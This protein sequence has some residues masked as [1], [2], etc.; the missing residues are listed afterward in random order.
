[1]DSNQI[2]PEKIRAL[3]IGELQ[4]FVAY[5]EKKLLGAQLQEVLTKDHLLALG[6]WS[7][8]RIWLV[9]DLNSQNPLPLLF[10]DELP[11]RAG[12][13]KPIQFFLKSHGVNRRIAKIEAQKDERILH[14]TLGLEPEETKIEVRLFPKGTNLLVFAGDKKI[15]LERVMD[16]T[17]PPQVDGGARDLDWDELRDKWVQARNRSKA[18]PLDPVLEW[19]KNKEK[20]IQKK[21]IALEKM[22]EDL[23]LKKQTP[24]FEIGDWI[25]VNQTARVPSQW[26]EYIDVKLG[27]FE[28]MQRAFEKAKDNKRKI[29]GNL[30]RIEILKK[31][32][33]TLE[34]SEF[35][36]SSKK[37]LSK[38]QVLKADLL[39][40]AGVQGRRFVFSEQFEAVFGKS[41]A[42]NIQL[43]RKAQAW[44]LW[45]HLRDFPGSHAFIRRP[46]N[47]NVS[48]DDLRKVAHWLVK[49]SLGKKASAGE[50]YAIVVTECRHVKPIK[51]DKLGRVT[52][53]HERH[54]V[55]QFK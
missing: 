55:I 7:R 14:M 52:Y 38:N 13:P 32:I 26:K 8:G 16:L 48:D 51:G 37:S 27:V 2:K 11:F 5:A 43:L 39:R 29:E 28:N 6:F 30:A 3:S 19:Q 10:D 31:E 44:D 18:E 12:S 23:L 47:H 15:S 21:K 42:E 35:A 9:F 50:K 34:R 17:A 46:R 1:M 22:E 24:W 49:E 33:E 40:V 53:H 25:K 4:N 54:F 41:A 20:Q 45:L 36:V